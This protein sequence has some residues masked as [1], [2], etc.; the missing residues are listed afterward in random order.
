MFGCRH[1]YNFVEIKQHEKECPERTIKCPY[2]E[3]KKDIQLKGYRE[4]AMLKE[5]A[6]DLN[7]VIEY[8]VFES[9]RCNQF[10]LT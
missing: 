10:D 1:N 6:V 4:H 8:D 5:C 3:C 2:V 9:P 7:H